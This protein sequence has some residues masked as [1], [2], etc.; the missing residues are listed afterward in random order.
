MT[1]Q[2]NANLDDLTNLKQVTTLDGRTVTINSFT[3]E[4]E[5]P[6][7]ID[8]SK[9]KAGDKYITYGGRVLVYHSP[10]SNV[11]RDSYPFLFKSEK[12]FQEYSFTSDGRYW[13]GQ[14][15]GHDDDLKEKVESKEPAIDLSRAKPG[16]RFITFGG[17]EVELIAVDHSPHG[18]QYP[19]SFREPTYGVTWTYTREGINLIGSTD[20][21]RDLKSLV[22]QSKPTGLSL[23][24]AKI[25]DC[26]IDGEDLSFR[27]ETIKVDRDERY[28]YLFKRIGQ[29]VPPNDFR[30]YTKGGVHVISMPEHESNLVR[31]IEEPRVDI[32][33]AK[34]GDRLR[35]RNGEVVVITS[36]D[37]AGAITGYARCPGTGW[38]YRDGRLRYGDERQDAVEL[39]PAPKKPLQK[40]IAERIA[41][42]GSDHVSCIT[43]SAEDFRALPVETIAGCAI[44]CSSSL[45]KGTFRVVLSFED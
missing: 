45:S 7:A 12:G 8:L 17:E 42:I 39:I 4:P 2:I 22:T 14:E 21:T 19:F 6:P 18:P 10:N 31:K 35:L 26:Y 27:L 20:R 11:F 30:S 5:R 32:S 16:D 25:G 38:F 13:L 23:E 36:L 28:P 43:V 44:S 15:P 3:V 29:N 41:V 1:N 24:D 40:R 33:A 37:T 34:V 9:A